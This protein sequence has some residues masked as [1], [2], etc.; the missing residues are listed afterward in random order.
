MKKLLFAATAAFSLVCANA[1]EVKFGAK[2]GLNLA[3]ISGVEE[4]FDTKML[5]SFNIGGFAEIKVSDKFFVQ[6]ELLYSVQGYKTDFSESFS[7]GGTTTS[8]NTKSTSK[9]NYLNIPVL[10]KYYFIDKLSL[11]AGPQFG[12]LLGVKNSFE[13]TSTFAGVTNS[14]SGSDTDKDGLATFDLGFNFGAGYDITENIGV[15]ARYNLGLTKINEK[16]DG[17]IK[18]SVIQVGVNYKF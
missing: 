18:N 7:F 5:A 1:Q 8:F 3:N 14:T 10:A 2:A 17:S 15:E 13:S 12:F 16:G 11:V 6:P 9:L 4:G